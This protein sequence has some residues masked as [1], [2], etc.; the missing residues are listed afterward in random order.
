MSVRCD[1]Q[2]VLGYCVLPKQKTH[3]Q[4]RQAVWCGVWTFD[5]LS[6]QATRYKLLFIISMV[7]AG[8]VVVVASWVGVTCSTGA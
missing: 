3:I 5:P 2:P 8:G 1:A 7:K 4:P 6:L